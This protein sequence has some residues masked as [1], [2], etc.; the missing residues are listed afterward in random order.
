VTLAGLKKLAAQGKV[1]REESVVLV[2]TGHTLKDP[3]YTIRY[4]RGEL[5]SDAEVGD[6]GSEI[7]TTQRNA[8]LVEASAD[9]VLR[10]LER[11]S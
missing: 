9:Q 2:L 10:E 11:F 5:L 7:E 1:S 8:I 6:L 4:H 3:D